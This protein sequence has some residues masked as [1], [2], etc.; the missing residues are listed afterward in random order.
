MRNIAIR[1]L[2]DLVAAEVQEPEKRLEKVFD[3]EASRSAEIVK[4]VLGASA[5]V[6]VAV[7]VAYFKGD[8]SNPKWHLPIGF[9]L[10]GFT[11]TYGLVR[12]HQMRK[13]HR[14]FVA[15]LLLLAE[16]RRIAPFIRR[17]RA[18]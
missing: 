14:E 16:L 7:L 2:I 5:A 18:K 1:E 15:A 4:W 13:A 17:Y 8:V 10:A 3:W 9:T 12:L 6:F 11:A